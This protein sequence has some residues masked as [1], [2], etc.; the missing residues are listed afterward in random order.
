MR[1]EVHPPDG[2]PGMPVTTSGRRRAELIALTEIA[3]S[4]PTANARPCNARSESKRSSLNESKP[5]TQ[6]GTRNIRCEILRSTPSEKWAN[7]VLWA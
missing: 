4:A 2:S 1:A 6:T 7:S 5:N 3:V